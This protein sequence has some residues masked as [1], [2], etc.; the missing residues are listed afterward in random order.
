MGVIFA[1][2][3]CGMMLG[4]LR[5]SL[6]TSV[7]RRRWFSTANML[8][9]AIAGAAISLMITIFVKVEMCVEAYYPSMAYQKGKVIDDGIRAQIYTIL[10][11]LLNDL[12]VQP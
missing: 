8:T 1:T 2:F 7:T 10:R 11:I 6:A 5:F 12:V 3:M 9:M 4:S